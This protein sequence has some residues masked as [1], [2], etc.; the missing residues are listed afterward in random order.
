MENSS[1]PWTTSLCLWLEAAPE[2]RQEITGADRGLA[3]HWGLAR[4][5]M[6]FAVKRG[7]REEEEEEDSTHVTERQ[8]LQRSWGCLR[9]SQGGI[10]IPKAGLGLLT[11]MTS[12]WGPPKLSLC[13]EGWD[14][15]FPCVGWGSRACTGSRLV[16]P[17]V[18]AVLSPGRGHLKSGGAHGIPCSPPHILPS[19]SCSTT[20]HPHSRAIF[21]SPPHGVDAALTLCKINHLFKKLFGFFFVS[22]AQIEFSTG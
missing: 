18:A 7:G 17:H 9:R 22:F 12:A 16:H 1:C 14:R 8:R 6:M 11:A 19:F 3:A 10:L 15:A 20:G 4:A 5:S 2:D 13:W 21:Q